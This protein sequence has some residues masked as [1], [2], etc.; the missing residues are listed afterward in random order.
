MS[1]GK[2]LFRL[3]EYRNTLALNGAYY[4]FKET[5][6]EKIKPLPNINTDKFWSNKTAIEKENLIKSSIYKDKIKIASSFASNISGKFLDIGFG[7]A[8]VEKI[9]QKYKF[10]DIYGIDISSRSVNEAKKTLKGTYVKAGILRIPFSN[11]YFEL[12]LALD[13]F[14]HLPQEKTFKAFNEV[15][16]VLKKNGLLV[17]SVPVNEDLEEMLKNQI[18]PNGH[19]RNYTPAIIKAELLVAGFEILNTHY[20]YAFKN[21][22]HFKK[23][24]SW[25]WPFKSW[26]PNLILIRARKK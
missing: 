8:E 26:S 23:L 12:V 2:N 4:Q 5:Y 24:L 22:Y 25:I 13:V 9:L 3:E 15:Y 10:I 20:L 19:L 21:L 14:E 11:Q 1:R 16:R 6:S 18:N 17:V 7:N